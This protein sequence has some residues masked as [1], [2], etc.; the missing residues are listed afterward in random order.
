MA[1][2]TRKNVLVTGGSG[3]IGSHLV[4]R[5]IE[6]GSNVFVPYRSMN[7]NSY[8]FLSDLHS[9]A[10]LI[11]SD[12]KDFKRIMD[13]VTKYEIE[14][15]FHLAA[16]PIV[17]TAF[18][19]PVETFETNI[20]GTVNILEAARLYGKVRGIVVVSSDKAYGKIPRASEKD[21]LS[22]DHPYDVSKSASDL[23]AQSYFHTYRMPVTVCRFGNVY[24]E[25]DIN[26]NRIVPGII[27]SLIL[28]EVLYIR[29]NGKFIRD[30]VY[31]EDVVDGMVLVQKNIMKAKG[32]AF[33]LSSNENLSVIELVKKIEK[34][35]NKKIKYKITSSSINEIPRQSVDFRKISGMFNWSP[36]HTL[37]KKIADILSWYKAY[38]SKV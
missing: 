20:M 26:F 33:N 34:I 13:V 2:L 10:T 9:R 28:N 36:K 32:H 1:G 5:L 30:Y 15:I 19:N 21:P 3:F 18:H 35:I 12:K 16:Q 24:G 11:H 37:N 6:I 29:S 4:K 23:I 7:P 25:G 22:G 38:F 27:K 31:V 17:T 14:Y 8:F